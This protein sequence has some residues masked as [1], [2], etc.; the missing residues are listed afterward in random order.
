M[1]QEK[2]S[3]TRSMFLSLRIR[4]LLIF[5]LLFVIAFA[6]V[7]R[8]FYTFA[9]DLAMENLRQDLMSTALTAAAGIDGDAHT[10]LYE[11]GQ[12]DDETYAEISEFL[13]SVKRTNPKAAGMYTYVKRPDNDDCVFFVTSAAYPPSVEPSP[14]DIAVL[15]QR[16][17]SGCDIPPASRPELG[18]PYCWED[19]LSVTMLNAA[20]SAAGAEEMLWADA[21]GEWLSGYA[22]VRNSDGE[23]VGAVGVDMCAADVRELQ[24]NIRRTILPTLGV[25][26]VVL[27]AVVF[28][29]AHG[30][31]RPVIALTKIADRIGQGDYDQDLSPLYS[32]ILRDEVAT[33]AQVFEIMVGK[34]HQRE[35]TLIRQV[36][37]LKIEIDEVKRKRQVS[38]I[39]ESDFFQDLQAKARRMRSRRRTPTASGDEAP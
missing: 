30:V 34:V 6:A 24:N 21:W 25:T 5:T 13:R 27:A 1:T 14:R 39:V 26:I 17:A 18:E 37:E 8:W 11:S 35:Q 23:I 31:T 15:E 29:V 19:E 20:I 12:M 22:P 28:A 33:L 36:K 38:E 7:F 10:R 16:K 9:T 3:T 32:N 4:L 2:K